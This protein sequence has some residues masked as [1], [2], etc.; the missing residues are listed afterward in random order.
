MKQKKIF[1][2]PEVCFQAFIFIFFAFTVNPVFAQNK[3]SK[4]ISL[5][6]NGQRVGN[7]NVTVIVPVKGGNRNVL[8]VNEQLSS[9]TKLI[10]PPNTTV[11]LESPGGRQ[12]IRSTQGKAIE[13]EIEFTNQGEN[14]KVN[15]KGAEIKNSVTSMLGYNYRTTNNGVTAASKGTEFTF[16]DLSESDKEKA[17]IITT[18]GSILITDEIPVSVNGQAVN[19]N[20]KGS[21]TTIS[22]SRV[23]SAGDAVFY[24]SD[25]AVEYQSYQQAINA[26]INELKSNNYPEDRADDLM[27]LGDL[28]MENEQPGLAIKYY[29]EASDIYNNIYGYDDYSTIEA[30][31]SLAEALIE[32]NNTDRGS[33]IVEDCINILNENLEFIQED[34]EFLDED[35]DEEIELICDELSEICE[36]LGWAYDILGDE[37]TSN[38]FYEMAD[39]GCE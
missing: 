22:V 20:R 35:D 12:T 33:K 19:N 18:Q 30:R 11:M 36:Y 2:I 9:G 24:S 23:Q 14:H 1:R 15:G 26:I 32:T 38:E 37:K 8:T 21:E 34:I 28:Y 10:I 6:N 4:V 3:T 31:L 5:G 7:A 29:N 17:S 39:E 13:Y 16:T 25:E 27:C